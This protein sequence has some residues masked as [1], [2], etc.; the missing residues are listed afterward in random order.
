MIPCRLLWATTLEKKTINMY[1]VVNYTVLRKNC[2]CL[3][4]VTA[5]VFINDVL[6]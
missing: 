3:W 6:S 5:A 4:A 2:P 1:L